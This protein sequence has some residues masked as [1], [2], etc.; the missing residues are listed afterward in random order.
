M[1]A[2]GINHTSAIL[3]ETPVDQGGYGFDAIAIGYVYFAPV[4]GVT[5]GEIFGHVFNEYL[6]ARYARRHSARFQPE[7]RLWTCYIGTVL[8]IPGL[9]LVGE[10]L[11]WHLNPAAI[12]IGWGMY[13]C[14]ALVLSVPITAYAVDF[15]P[16]ASG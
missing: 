8:R 13:V 14:G 10:A 2:V 1:W 15:Y 6:T 12:V 3:F 9:I 4:L 5:I 16:Q 11:R 7:T